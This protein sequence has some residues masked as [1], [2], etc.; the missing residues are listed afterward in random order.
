MAR[1]LHGEFRTLSEAQVRALAVLHAPLQA[2]HF[3][4]ADDIGVALHLGHRQSHD[5]DF[6]RSQTAAD[7]ADLVRR[8]AIEVPEL[9]VIRTA[10]GTVVGRLLG[11]QVSLFDHEPALLD[12]PE[13]EAASGTPVAGQD[14]LLAMKLLAI[15]NR[16]EKRDFIDLYCMLRASGEGLGHALDCLQRRYGAD[17][18]SALRALVFFDDA[19]RAPDPVL[20]EPLD[21]R[22]VKAFFRREVA[23]WPIE[24]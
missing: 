1:V 8:L 21:W 19:D 4:L 13:T 22:E 5:L 3:Y 15:Q 17:P 9:T 23:R 10:P 24:R 7:P 20:V 16:G 18:Y 14:D 6:F 12:A 11:V 2:L